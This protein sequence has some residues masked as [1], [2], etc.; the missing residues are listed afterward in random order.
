MILNNT[1]PIIQ[2]PPA[3][4]AT[5]FAWLIWTLIWGGMGIIL[6]GAVLYYFFKELL[7]IFN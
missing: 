4:F 5:E 7:S 1:N 2:E 3:W 6:V